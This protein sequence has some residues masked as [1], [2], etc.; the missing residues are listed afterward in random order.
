MIS[1]STTLSHVREVVQRDKSN[2][3]KGAYLVD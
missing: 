3:V 1:A 2:V